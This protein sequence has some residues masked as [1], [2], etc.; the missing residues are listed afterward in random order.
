[1]GYSK[2]HSILVTWH[3]LA[4][5]W[6]L[7]AEQSDTLAQAYSYERFTQMLKST[8]TTTIKFNI[9]NNQDKEKRKTYLSKF[10]FLFI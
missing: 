7:F 4:G 5:H 6:V 2:H 9:E 8:K 1:M 10:F 3:C